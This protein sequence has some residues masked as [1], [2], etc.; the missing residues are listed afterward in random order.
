MQALG[1]KKEGTSPLTKNLNVVVKPQLPFLFSFNFFF[2]AATCSMQ[3]LSSLTRDR[4]HAL[5]IRSMESSPLGS[6]NL[7]FL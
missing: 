6:S 3:D 4:T 7:S 1:A 5:C 2:K